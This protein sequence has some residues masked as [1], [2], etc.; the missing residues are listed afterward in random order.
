MTGKKSSTEDH[1][2]S[3]YKA[4]PALHDLGYVVG[5][6]YWLFL[7]TVAYF[8]VTIPFLT[9][10]LSGDSIFN[11]D[12]THD[13]LKFR[14]I[15]DSYLAVVLAGAVVLGMIG[16]IASFRFLQDKKETT[17]FFSLGLT[18]MR[19]FANRCVSGMV[20][21]FLG[22]AIPMLVSM[23]LNI[24]ALGVYDG[25]I[26][27][28][29]YLTAGLTV[30]A[31]FSFLAAAIVSALAGTMAETIVYWCGLMASP[32]AV[33]FALNQLMN[34]LFWGSAW[35]AVPYSGTD[36][37]K[38]DLMTNFAWLDP[39]TFF[40][41]DMQTHSQYMR[42][43]AEPIVPSIEPGRLIG[44]CVAAAVLLVL[45]IVF[46]RK[47]KAEV[48]GISGTNR[49]LSEWLIA[50]TSFFVFTLIF[51]FL[52]QFSPRLSFVLGVVGF[53]VVHLFWRKALFSYGTNGLRRGISLAAGVV[54][55][56]VIC[57]AF[58]TGGAGSVE[59]YL[60]SGQAVAAS[61]SYVGSP[62]YLYETATGS[63][64][65]RGYYLT[66]DLTFETEE[67]IALVQEIQKELIADGRQALATNADDFEQ[68]VIPYDLIFAYTDADGT[69]HIWYYDRASFAQ[70]EELLA[71]E[72][73]STVREGVDALFSGTLESESTVWASEAY[74]SGTLYLSNIWC[75][76]T[77]ELD[78]SDEQRQE[79]LAA[80][81]AD[82]AAQTAE[83][84]YFPDE[85]AVA[86]LMF[87][88]NGEY[89]CQYYAFNLDNSFVYVTEEDANLIAWLQEYELLDLVTA[90]VEIE[91]IT[92]QDFDPYIGMN[93]LSYPF[94]VYFMSYR[95]DSLDEFMIQKDFGDK[96][97]ITG[98]DRIENMKSR[99]R[100]GYF[101]SGGGYL[102]AV[103]IAGTEGYV[104]MFLPEE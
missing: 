1:S 67:E 60:D 29:F 92:L 64:T 63:S 30:T 62:S 2:K 8:L 20:M 103:K 55:S 6:N 90:D 44:W 85:Q 69:E 79:L 70:L 28:T 48:A 24:R 35:G 104:Y 56:L 91:S 13:Q 3:A 23:G 47:R 19:L 33:C 42:P 27:N 102:A 7:I 34:R 77:F 22:I 61:V 89:D 100:N 57:G 83:E 86:V 52:Y 38:P 53:A 87:S 81:G 15:H 4:R 49:I 26:R 10:G 16:G 12:V 88:R 80:I 98:A 39:F 101:M 59:R 95:A 99:L 36:A 54:V 31:V 21:L 32:Y 76:Q 17:I 93:D 84:F 82:R 72:D 37:V 74:Q 68:T 45:A 94:G 78:L 71:L 50:V 75:T 5:R 97:T 66:S 46:M 43:L 73:T 14:L 51:S 11:I 65:G 25:L 40:Y 9:A 58:S 18:R 96:N 41:E